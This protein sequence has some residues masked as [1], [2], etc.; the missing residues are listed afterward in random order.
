MRGMKATAWLAA[1]VFF[2]QLPIPLYWLVFHPAIGYWRRHGKSVYVTAVLLS[3]GPITASL[4]LFHTQ[5]FRPGWPRAWEIAVGFALIFFEVWVFRRVER[6]LGSARMAGHSELRGGREIVSSGIYSRVRNPRYAGSFLALIGAGLLA[7][8]RLAWIAAGCWALLVLV[9]VFLEERELRAR[10]GEPYLEYCRR[11]P[12]FLPF[13]PPF[14]K[15][16]ATN[17]FQAPDSL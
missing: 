8:T 5:L 16:R 7:G 17:E 6:D 3:W 2:L 10:L 11:V 1:L 12:R 13:R 14:T 15:T 4:F 9:V